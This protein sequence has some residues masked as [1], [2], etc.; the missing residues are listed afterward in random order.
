MYL[1][2]IFGVNLANFH[3]PCKSLS[4]LECHHPFETNLKKFVKFF[5]FHLQSLIKALPLES[6]TV[7]ITI[8]M[9]KAKANLLI[10]CKLDIFSYEILST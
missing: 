1:N 6:D 4:C 7:L 8:E 9:Q 3:C 2:R 5:K 10:R